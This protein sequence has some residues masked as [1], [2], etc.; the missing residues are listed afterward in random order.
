VRGAAADDATP[1]RSRAASGALVLLLFAFA[2]LGV[3]A[4]VTFSALHA[5]EYDSHVRNDAP[6]VPPRGFLSRVRAGEP[7][8]P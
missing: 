6:S 5:T 2:L 7:A 4:F 1:S 3:G 8:R